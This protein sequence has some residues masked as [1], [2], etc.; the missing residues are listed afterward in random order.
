M[1]YTLSTSFTSVY[2]LKYLHFSYKYV[3]AASVLSSILMI[4]SNKFWGH[5]E[6]KKGINFVMGATSFFL[7]MELLILSFLNAGTGALL[8][9]SSAVSGF[10]TGGFAISIMT[11]RYSIMPQDKRTIY[12]G[13]YY[14]FYGLGVLAAPFIGRILTQDIPLLNSG[15][16]G[17]N[18]FQLLY[19][20][21]FALMLVLLLAVFVRPVMK[22]HAQ[23]TGRGSEAFK[24]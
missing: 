12:E 2:L 24:S 19:L 10:G 13:W 9:L 14:F 23:N 18:K 3:S 5:I 20:V 17:Y 16:S 11:Y 22:K 15:I 21:S 1:A 8:I 7:A 4:A 6:A